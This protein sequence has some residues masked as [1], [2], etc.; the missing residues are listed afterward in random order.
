MDSLP[1]DLGKRIGRIED[2]PDE[3]RRQLQLSEMTDLDREII[4]VLRDDLD[5]AGNLN[6]I[7]VALYRRKNKVHERTALSNK[8]YRMMRAGYVTSIKG[9]K[10]A[11][12]LPP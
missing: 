5:G 1:A 8:L 6:E 4:A 9:K 10:G 12:M 2:L 3:L 7:L 11:Y